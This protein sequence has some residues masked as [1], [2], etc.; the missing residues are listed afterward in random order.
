MLNLFK[1]YFIP[2]EHNDHKPHI[3][4]LK[5][6]LFLLGLV[7]FF[8][9]L[10][11]VQ[12]FVISPKLK[13]FAQILENVLVD[14]TNNSRL[15]NSLP[16]L[17]VNPLLSA[18]AQAKAEDMA[19]KG[20]FAHTS[21]EGVTPWY[22]I[23][24]FGYQYTHAGENLAINF[25]DS[26]DVVDA[27]MNSLKHRDN[28]LNGNFTEIGIGLAKGIYQKKETVFIVQMFGRPVKTAVSIPAKTVAVNPLPKQVATQPTPVKGETIQPAASAGVTESSPVASLISEV[29]VSPRMRTAYIFLAILAVISLALALNIF[30]KVKIQHPGIIANGIALIF[31]IN[32]MLFVNYCLALLPAKIF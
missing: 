21:P 31:I 10:F 17:E 32:A 29:L 23:E 24:K 2:H 16:G 26:K 11:L 5:A 20:Y 19:R 28:I 25:S 8:E 13:F 3:L 7:I 14:K 15:S 4:R 22:W 27:W 30:I 6:A 12:V 18:A 1:K 9:F